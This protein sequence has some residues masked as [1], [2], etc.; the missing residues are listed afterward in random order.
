[1]H[2]HSTT[3]LPV[4]TRMGMRMGHNLAYRMSLDCVTLFLASANFFASHFNPHSQKSPVLVYLRSALTH[5]QLPQIYSVPHE[6]QGKGT[7]C[8]VLRWCTIVPAI[9]YLF[10]ASAIPKLQKIA[11]FYL[12]LSGKLFWSGST[13]SVG[14]DHIAK[15]RY[16]DIELNVLFQKSEHLTLYL[17]WW[18][19]YDVVN[20]DSQV[21]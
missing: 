2:C 14:S 7:P 4:W 15:L 20:I 17:V 1:M 21:K 13:I 12:W 6:S 19:R 9:P 18:W 8:N 16:L 5:L 10:P 11:H 3:I